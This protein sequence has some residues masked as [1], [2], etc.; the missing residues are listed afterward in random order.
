MLA[1]A[2]TGVQPML[3]ENSVPPAQTTQVAKNDQQGDQT[4]G[5]VL[6]MN[7]ELV[8]TNVVVRDTKTG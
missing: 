4:S 1:L 7:G 6:K 5:F 8:L 3:A 2:Q